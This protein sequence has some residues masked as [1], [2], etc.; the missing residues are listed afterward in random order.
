MHGQLVLTRED[1][2]KLQK[3]PQAAAMLRNAEII[4]VVDSVAAGVQGMA[5]RPAPDRQVATALATP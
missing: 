3:D 4:I 1:A 2:E 5:P